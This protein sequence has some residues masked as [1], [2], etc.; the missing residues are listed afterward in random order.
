MGREALARVAIGAEQGEVKALLE[1][2]ELILRGAVRRRFAR[3]AV[4]DVAATDGVLTFACAGEEV[5]LVLGPGIAEAWQRAL[6]APP[7][8]LRAKLGLESGAT[9]VVLGCCDDPALAAALAGVTTAQAD[10]ADLVVARIDSPAEL[11][12]ARAVAAGRPLWVVYP[13]GKAAP[14]GDAAVRAAMRVAGWRDTKAC[15]VSAVLTATR[16]HPPA[17]TG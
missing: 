14:F 5:R 12:Q 10:V 15:A 7:P 13:K 6:L 11:G 2:Q 8:S 3:D 16:Y 9:A 1:G 17:G 4:H